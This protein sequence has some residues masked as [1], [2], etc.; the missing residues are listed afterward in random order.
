MTSIPSTDGTVPTQTI[1]TPNTAV[2]NVSGVGLFGLITMF[3][4][5]VVIVFGYNYGASRLAYCY[6]TR[7]GYGEG[8]AFIFSVLAW[9]FSGFYYPIH[10]IFLSNECVVPQMGGRRRKN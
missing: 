4:F 9:L 7:S 3:I 1:S 10:A 5:I 8:V 6:M 2:T